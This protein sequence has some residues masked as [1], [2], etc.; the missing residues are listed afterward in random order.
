[1]IEPA[2]VRT[3]R[4][5]RN[6]R[7][8]PATDNR[9]VRIATWNV[10][11]LK[12][13]MDRVLEWLERGQPDVLLIQETKLADDDAPLLPFQMRGYELVHHGEGRWNGVAIA[14]RLPIDPHSIVTN[15]GDSPVRNSAAG[16]DTDSAE[17]DFNPFD[18]ARMLSATIGGIRFVCLYAPNGRVVDSPFYTGK[19]AWYERLRSWLA[20]SAAPDAPLVLGGDMNVAPEPIDVW[21]EAQA[22]GGTHVSARER[23]AFAALLG[24]GLVD[25]YRAQRPEPQRFSW[26]DYRAGNF[27][28]NLG[29]RIDHLLVTPPVAERVIWAEIDRE[30]RKGQPVPSDHAPLL[31]DLDQPGAPLDAGW[32][33]ALQRIAARTRPTRT[34]ASR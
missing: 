27:H 29:M 18:E 12:A 3:V 16:A 13:R 7:I 15:F 30:A 5:L 22:H 34:E 23:E 2:A 14:S 26:W 25:A 1:M 33:A 10:N 9:R 4:G 31:I 17:E 11:S 21:N 20:E 32:D 19:L 28:K 6:A 24:W 8:G